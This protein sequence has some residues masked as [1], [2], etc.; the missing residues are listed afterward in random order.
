M[1][2][3]GH[4][5]R[6]RRSSSLAS[7]LYLALSSKELYKK[8]SSCNMIFNKSIQGHKRVTS[9]R[10]YRVGQIVS[11]RISHCNNTILRSLSS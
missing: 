9:S 6:D 4:C 11:I 8:A 1:D 7:R 3:V 2:H 10:F 5:R